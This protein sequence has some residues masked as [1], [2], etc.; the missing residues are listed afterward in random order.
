MG[1]KFDSGTQQ[2]H[3]FNDRISY[4]MKILRNNQ[5]GQLYSG[6]RV[7]IEQDYTYLFEDSK[8]PTSANVFQDEYGFSLDL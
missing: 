2:F 4:V 5:I 3:L 8:R 6:K 7:P 1:I